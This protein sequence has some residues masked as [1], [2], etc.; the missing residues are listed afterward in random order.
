V[1]SAVQEK[2]EQGL[3]TLQ[4]QSVP[5][6]SQH[7]F[8][9]LDKYLS[10]LSKWNRVYNLTAVRDPAQMVDRHL[11]DSLMMCRWLPESTNLPNAQ[12]DVMD[13]GSG[14]GLP[15]L[16]LAIARPDL[17]FVSVESNGK[18]T[19]FQQQS[20]LELNLSNVTI[21]NDRVENVQ[22]NARMVISRAFTAPVDFL[23]IALPLCAKNG[24]VVIML[25]QADRFPA[26]TPAGYDLEVLTEVDVP[27]TES[28]RHVAV[29]RRH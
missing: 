23:E 13:I 3:E 12:F 2:L 15:V 27:G 16:P 10:L 11:M 28:A 5:N 9:P 6:I 8:E 4:A 18:K 7:L 21:V 29:C 22:Q 26:Q 14:A 24:Q 25:G 20:L 1:S 19:R 17:S